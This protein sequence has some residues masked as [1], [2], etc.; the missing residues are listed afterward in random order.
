MTFS[1]RILITNEKLKDLPHQKVDAPGGQAG[2][3]WARETGSLLIHSAH[4]A[5]LRAVL[6]YPSW[7][8]KH[9]RETSIADWPEPFDCSSV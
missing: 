5:C 6:D 1:S 8:L 7:P 2:W 3:E 9:M 4:C